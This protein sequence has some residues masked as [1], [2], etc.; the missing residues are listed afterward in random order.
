MTKLIEGLPKGVAVYGASS[1]EI[2]D[3]YLEAARQIGR[4][5]ADNNTPVV[6]GGGRGGIMAA[7]TE[8]ALEKGGTA[9]GVLPD[10]MIERGWNHPMLTHTITTESMQERKATMAALSCGAIAMPGGVGTLDELFELITWRQLGLYSGNVVIC[11]IYGFY[12]R[13]L[14]HLS[15]TDSLNF[16][17][18]GGPSKL[19]KTARTPEEAVDMALNEPLGTVPPLK[20]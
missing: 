11:N 20:Y 2:D 16:M 17:R 18:A 12:D 14:E 3:K 8:G 13:L 9:I 15:Y 10:F 4:L 7:V 19:W 1:K 5:L 6:S